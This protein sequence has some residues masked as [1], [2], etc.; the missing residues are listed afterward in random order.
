MRSNCGLARWNK[1]PLRFKSTKTLFA[2]T[3][4]VLH[5]LQNTSPKNNAGAC[6]TASLTTALR[7]PVAPF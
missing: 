4:G 5:S 3:N 2:G 1:S 7:V 6:P